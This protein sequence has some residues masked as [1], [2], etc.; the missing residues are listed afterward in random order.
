VESSP[1]PKK[2][3]AGR[4]DNRGE[5]VGGGC[6]RTTKPPTPRLATVEAAE[7][8]L[9]LRVQGWGGHRR[10]RWRLPKRGESRDD[11]EREESM[12]VM[13]MMAGGRRR[14]E[15]KKKEREDGPAHS[16]TRAYQEVCG[17]PSR[18]TRSEYRTARKAL[19]LHTHKQTAMAHWV[20]P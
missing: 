16:G 9:V 12:A 18:P 8:S 4:E 10:W 2:E 17:A 3:A 19:Q 7:L 11:Q 13:M 6:R 1:V 14:S 15:R 5:L 20:W